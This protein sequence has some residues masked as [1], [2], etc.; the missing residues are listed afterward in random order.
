MLKIQELE[1]LVPQFLKNSDLLYVSVLDI[2]GQIYLANKLF[3]ELLEPNGA[4]IL[5]KNFLDTCH[6]RNNW[7]FQD[8]LIQVIEKPLDKLHVELVHGKNLLIKWEFTALQNEEGDFSGILAV[9]HKHFQ[10]FHNPIPNTS[11]YVHHE[12]PAD[13]L[14]SLDFAWEIV[15]INPNAEVFFGKKADELIGQTI[16]QVYPDLSVYQ[17]ALEFKKARTSRSFRVFEEFN[18]LNGRFYKIFVYPKPL[19]LDLIFQ[20]ITEIHQ[21]SKE[22]ANKNLNLEALIEH[23]NEQILFVGK[24]LRISG[25]NS[26]AENFVKKQF[27]RTPRHGDKFLNYLPDNMDE[28][29]LKHLEEILGG[30]TFH[31]EKEIFQPVYKKQIWFSHKFYPLKDLN[32]G[33]SGFVYAFIDIHEDKMGLAK[34]QKQN[35]LMREVLYTQSSTLRSP[36]SSILGLLELIDKDQMDKENKKYLAYLKTLAQELDKVIRNN[37]KQVSDLD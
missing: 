22:L 13:V 9:G 5:E 7:D 17:H 1:T 27:G 11:L 35:K 29:F 36:L 37:S 10:Q 16:W 20:D 32:G 4:D 34:L 30:K 14:V 8:F 19:G 28:F 26:K 18:S 25:F 31:V 24:D 12:A 21:L 15:D 2:E 23:A 3:E 6:S 33:V